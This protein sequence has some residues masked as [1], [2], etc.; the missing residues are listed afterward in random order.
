MT[1]WVFIVSL[2]IISLSLWGLWKLQKRIERRE[3]LAAGLV[4]PDEKSAKRAKQ[5]APIQT[6]VQQNYLQQFNPATQPPMHPSMP[7][8]TQGATL[9]QE[10]IV[11]ELRQPKHNIRPEERQHTFIGTATGGGKTQASLSM[12]LNDMNQGAQVYWLNPQYTLY[13]PTDQPTDLRGLDI[14]AIDDIGEI[15]R[16]LLAQATLPS[17]LVRW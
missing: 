12:M 10:T 11:F 6:P 2:V 9:P 15:E 3:Q 17:R 5:A 14:I 13:H 8:V 4:L 1:F 7:V 16:C